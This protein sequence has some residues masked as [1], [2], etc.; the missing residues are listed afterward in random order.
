MSEI[1]AITLVL[2]N[3]SRAAG[4]LRDIFGWDVDSDY[5]AFASVALPSGIPLWINAP[6]ADGSVTDN[7]TIHLSAADVDKAFDD[8]V[9]RGAQALREPTDMDYGE[10]SAWVTS[11]LTPGVVFDF[12][13][14]LD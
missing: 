13:R 3:P 6:A 7:V 14:P 1:R 11:E 8:A 12:S 9:A 10:R 5:G 2:E 4:A